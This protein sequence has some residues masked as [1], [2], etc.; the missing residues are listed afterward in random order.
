[1]SLSMKTLMQ[2]AGAYGATRDVGDAQQ[3]VNLRRPL[4]LTT[5][6]GSGQADLFFADTR[7]LSA[8]ATESLDLAGGLTDAFGASLTFVEIVALLITADAGNTNNVEVGGAASNA[9]AALFGDAT[10]KVKLKPG[11][12]LM[13]A[14][15]TGYAVTAGTGD[16]L[17]IA[18]GGSGTAVTYTLTLIGRSA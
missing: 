12:S 6:T 8:S 1:M 11:A 15:E 2:I 3:S 5:G 9:W 14:C 18:N 10:D 16:L 7:T 17:K 13:L 4:D